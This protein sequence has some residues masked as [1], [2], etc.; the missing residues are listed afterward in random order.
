MRILAAVTLASLLAVPASAQLLEDGWNKPAVTVQHLSTF[1]PGVYSFAQEWAIPSGR[2]Q[3][4]ATL[5]VF[6][7]GSAGA[8]DVLLNYRYQ[9]L[10]RETLAV[11]PRLSLVLPTGDVSSGLGRGSAGV[12]LNVPVSVTFSPRL[13]AHTN[14]GGVAYAD[15][16]YDLVAGQNAI[17]GVAA[18]LE[19]VG[20]V[21]WTRSRLQHAVETDLSLRPGMQWRFQL[22]GI[23]VV[24]GVAFP[25]G[26]EGRSSV[27]YLSFEHGVTSPGD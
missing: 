19:L 2:H 14:L 22:R 4:G 9:L 17:F 1:T 8:G 10:N 15:G 18:G 16:S 6:F 23:D 27:L 5:P 11:A 20:E 3:T 21:I 13:T 7:D 24:P 12:L 25:I 26:P